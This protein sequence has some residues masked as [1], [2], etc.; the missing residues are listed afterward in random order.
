MQN[1]YPVS[2]SMELWSLDKDK[3][4]FRKWRENE[5]VLGLEKPYLSAVGT[6]MYLANQTCPDISFDVSL[7]ACHSSQLM[8]RHWNDIKRVFP[9]LKGT[10]NMGLL[11]PNETNFILSSYANVGYLSDPDDAKSQ[12]GYVF[13]QG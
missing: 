4:M 7:L 12:I 11:F 1:A 5:Q 3:D 2:T 6:L 9:Y 8:L 13:L 10:A